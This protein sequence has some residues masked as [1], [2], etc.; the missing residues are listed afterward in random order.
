MSKKLTIVLGQLNFLVG[1]VVGNIEKMK[2]AIATAQQQWQADLIVFPELALCGYPPEDLLFHDGFKQQI[3]QGLQYLEKVST[4]IAIIVGFPDYIDSDIY[5]AAAFIHAGHIKQVYHKQLLPNYGVFDE[6]RYFVAGKKNSIIEFK[7]INIGLLICE[8]LWY[9]HPI[10]DCVAKDAE[11]VICINAS[12]FHFEKLSER[13]NQLH[14]HATR[15]ALPIIYLQTIGGQDELVFDGGSFVIN[16]VGE[17]TH[18]SPLLQEHLLPVNYCFNRKSFHQP[19]I[20]RPELALDEHIYK[21][22][23]L[24]VKDYVTKNKFQGVVLGLSGGIDSALV[25]AI[26]VDALG[27]DNVQALMMPSRHTADMSI[28][29]A[30]ILAKQAGVSYRS[31]SIEPMYN[32]FL[33]Q[34]ATEFTGYDV[35]TTEENIQARIRGMILMAIS[36]KKGSLVLTTGNK[37]EMAVGYATLYGDMAGGFSVLK[38]VPKTWVYQ[39][40]NYRNRQ[41]PLIPERIITRPPSAELSPDQVD[42]DSLPPYSILDDILALYVEQDKS[43]EA[44]I[45]AGHEA[46]IVDQVLKMVDQNVYKRRQ[47]PPGIRITRRAFGRERRFPITS[48]FQHGAFNEKD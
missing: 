40:A 14:Y 36:N 22:L 17:I 2:Q 29:D 28:E 37:S 26:A 32:A 8:D 44:I 39:L 48:G 15:L 38:D 20:T 42:E 19:Y 43:R 12:P 33:I 27:A 31:I 7:G 25:L 11:M 46:N 47:A 23:V 34:L 41:Q 35:N 24:G 18:S 1:D 3:K 45:A 9:D 30:Q 6:K 21:V 13:K 5:N 4:N 16:N 10:T